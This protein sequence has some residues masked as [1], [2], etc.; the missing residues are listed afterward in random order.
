MKGLVY[1]DFYLSKKTFLLYT[2][3]ALATG[4]F[5]VLM[6]LSSRCGNLVSFADNSSGEFEVLINI[7]TY[8][9]IILI[10]VSIWGVSQCI[11]SDYKSGWMYYSYTLPERKSIMAGVHYIVSILVVLAGVIYGIIHTYIIRSVAGLDITKNN[12][13]GIA[14]VGIIG[15][16]YSVC[17]IPLS[18]VCKTQKRTQTIIIIWGVV[19]YI[20]SMI[21]FN[22]LEVDDE[23]VF[24][25]IWADIKPVKDA[26]VGYWWIILPLILVLSISIS[27]RI[28]KKNKF[29]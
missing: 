8:I 18:L 12:M 17:L 2:V 3:L 10:V 9:P 21:Q 14:L 15:V 11:F 22:L 13:I 27:V 16:I 23:R 4:L 7:F 1:R 26:L 29:D 20:V 6:S 25:I 24:K 19:L 28:L 5:G